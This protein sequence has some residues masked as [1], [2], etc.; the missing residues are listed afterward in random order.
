MKLLLLVA[1]AALFRT[2]SAQ[3]SICEEGETVMNPDKMIP[4]LFTAGKFEEAASCGEVET[5]AQEDGIFSSAECILVGSFIS[6]VCGCTVP[7]DPPVTTP[8]DA[9]VA[10]PIDGKQKKNLSGYPAT[11]FSDFSLFS[12]SLLNSFPRPCAHYGT[13]CRQRNWCPCDA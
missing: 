1:V 12:S 4:P 6:E 9:P 8:T 11:A 13:C 5:A 3:C 2:A 7:T 10:P